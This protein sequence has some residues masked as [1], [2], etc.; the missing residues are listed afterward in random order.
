MPQSKFRVIVSLEFT[1]MLAM[2]IGFF[3]LLSSCSPWKHIHEKHKEKTIETIDSDTTYKSKVVD[4]KVKGSEASAQGSNFDVRIR[5]SVIVKF[6]YRYK[7]ST[8][9][10]D[11][12]I[13]RYKN[14]PSSNA[15][16]NHPAIYA[17]NPYGF[18]KAWVTNGQL[19]TSFN[20]YEQ[21]IQAK[22]DSA[23]ILIAN[24]RNKETIIEDEKVEVKRP[25]FNRNTFIVGLVMIGLYELI[26]RFIKS[27]FARWLS[28]LRR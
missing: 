24:T 23:V 11:S 2:I 12:V 5:D 13:Y 3:L 27:Y 19:N 22:V 18:S 25:W 28:L 4:V 15:I 6:K 1:A 7:D 10:R 9:V 26:K 8:I 14:I 20:I 21:V 17:F 16:I